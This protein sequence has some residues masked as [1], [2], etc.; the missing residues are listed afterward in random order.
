MEHTA[1]LNFFIQVYNAHY[2]PWAHRNILVI[3]GTGSGKTTLVNA[4]INEMVGHSPSERVFI[5][6]DT[7]EIQCCAENFVQYHTTLDV[8]MTQ[9]LKTT[10]RMRPHTYRGQAL[11]FAF[12]IWSFFTIRLK[13]KKA[14]LDPQNFSS[15]AF[16]VT[17]ALSWGCVPG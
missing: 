4:I 12:L 9:L 10:L 8:N 17:V 16:C 11:L 3:G 5:I 1:F 2:I 6:E 13:S 15:E 7:G 14:R